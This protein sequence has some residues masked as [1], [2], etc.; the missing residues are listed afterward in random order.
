MVNN[1]VC[2]CLKSLLPLIEKASAWSSECVGCVGW[3]LREGKL[4][5]LNFFLT[6]CLFLK[7]KGSIEKD[8]YAVKWNV[9]EVFVFNFHW[10]EILDNIFLKIDWWWIYKDRTKAMTAGMRARRVAPLNLDAPLHPSCPQVSQNS[11]L[12]YDGVVAR[13]HWSAGALMSSHEHDLEMTTLSLISCFIFLQ[14]GRDDCA[15]P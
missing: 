3:F 4:T 15:A 10:R 1:C 2:V 13:M 5:R 9:E 12:I 11:V 6:R 8:F 14:T 7:M